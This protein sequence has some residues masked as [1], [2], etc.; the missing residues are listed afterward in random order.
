MRNELNKILMQLPKSSS[1]HTLHNS[2]DR[3]KHARKAKQRLQQA[4]KLARPNRQQFLDEQIQISY[5]K[6]QSTK[7]R[8][9][10]CISNAEIQ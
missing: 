6:Q 3:R 9:L 4:R 1:I 8:Q 7:A 10:K 2:Q 5:H